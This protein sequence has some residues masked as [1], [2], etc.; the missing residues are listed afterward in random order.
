MIDKVRK[1][2]KLAKRYLD[3]KPIVVVI[4]GKRRRINRVIAFVL[5]MTRKI[6]WWLLAR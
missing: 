1:L 3:D 5:W 2:V 4:N 6:I